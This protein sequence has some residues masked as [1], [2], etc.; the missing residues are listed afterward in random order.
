ML[1][2]GIG[3]LVDQIL[4]KKSDSFTDKISPEVDKHL[5]IVR[6]DETAPGTEHTVEETNS[7]V[8]A[9]K[10]AP[11]VPG[12]RPSNA[13]QSA[14]LS[15]QSQSIPT[16][17]GL[18]GAARASSQHSSQMSAK[19]ADKKDHDTINKKQQHDSVTKQQKVISSQNKVKTESAQELH[20]GSSGN[21]KVAVPSNQNL[22]FS[23]GGESSD[24]KVKHDQDGSSV[25]HKEIDKKPGKEIELGKMPK[26]VDPKKTKLS[27]IEG[28]SN[29]SGNEKASSIKV[30]TKPSD[31]K[32]NLKSNTGKSAESLKGDI[33]ITDKKVNIER[34][35]THEKR[36]I[37]T[38]HIMGKAE[39]NMQKSNEDSQKA[40]QVT[41]TQSMPKTEKSS[42][43]ND[44]P[45]VKSLKK[46]DQ[47]ED[48]LNIIKPKTV[49][50]TKSSKGTPEVDK[51]QK[52]VET[53]V[54][55]SDHDDQCVLKVETL[56][57]KGPSVD[58][59]AYKT[60]ENTPITKKEGPADTEPSVGQS[61]KDEMINENSKV[62]DE[63][64]CG[65]SDTSKQE[66][67]CVSSET[68]TDSIVKDMDIDTDNDVLQKKMDESDETRSSENS[69]SLEPH[70]GVGQRRVKR[71]KRLISEDGAE[72]SKSAKIDNSESCEAAPSNEEAKIVIDES[73]KPKRGR[74]RPRKTGSFK[75]DS[76]HSSD[77][78]ITAEESTNEGPNRGEPGKAKV[79]KQEDS[80]EDS[81]LKRQRSVGSESN[82]S[83]TGTDDR[84]P[85]TNR[86]TRRQI[87]PKRCYSPSD[88][89]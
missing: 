35:E 59:D 32:D 37:E 8:R 45:T 68:I 24:S 13:P 72:N 58:K 39:H 61:G 86:R 49:V 76:Q 67:V 64:L 20:V 81:W 71:R 4:T 44:V 69:S 83:D 7:S 18:Q 11:N 52:K 23:K 46:E 53:V 73:P 77:N 9:Q 54:K 56:M 5:G 25:K 40:T 78:D 1:L 74:G 75:S 88:G 55:A 31:I 87:K 28:K 43:C 41:V 16:S 6:S 80:N 65:P 89:K 57:K 15:E 38:K 22:R 51:I 50:D 30:E 82:A 3:N 26:D 63:S 48:E 34:K 10:V 12:T 47:R 33:C 21:A 27:S 17:S 62:D 60:G 29:D 70:F 66:N 36:D 14:R 84:D 2:N 42:S 85:E 19:F 79:R